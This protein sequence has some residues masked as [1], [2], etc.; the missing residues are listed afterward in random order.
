MIGLPCFLQVST[1]DNARETYADPSSVLVPMVIFRQITP[2][3]K[4]L[5][6]ALFVGSM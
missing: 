4:A 6:A 2:G 3:L 5:S 1:A